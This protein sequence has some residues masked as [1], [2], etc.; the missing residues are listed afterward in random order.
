MLSE[1]GE[2]NPRREQ[3]WPCPGP[4][5]GYLNTR[6]KARAVEDPSTADL[7]MGTRLTQAAESCTWALSWEGRAGGTL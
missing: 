6:R 3:R 1:A 2:G 5:H 7:G 4:T